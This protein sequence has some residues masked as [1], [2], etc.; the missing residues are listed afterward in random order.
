MPYPVGGLFPEWILEEDLEGKKEEEGEDDPRFPSVSSLENDAHVTIKGKSEHRL[1]WRGSLSV[2]LKLSLQFL[3]S[4][5][6][7]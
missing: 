3:I 4:F 7:R 5:L 2:I 6:R 1:L